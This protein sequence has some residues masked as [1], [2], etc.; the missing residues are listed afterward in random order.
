[1]PDEW[2]K[3]FTKSFGFLLL[4]IIPPFIHIRAM[5]LTD[6]RIVMPSVL[7]WGHHL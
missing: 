4:I 7:S 3:F 2:G 5:A 1:M 6:R